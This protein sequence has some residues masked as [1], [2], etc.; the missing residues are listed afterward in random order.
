MGL[1]NTREPVKPIHLNWGMSFLRV[2]PSLISSWMQTFTKICY[3]VNETLWYLNIRGFPGGSDDR[4]STCNARDLSSIPG[5]GRWS[6]EGMATHSSILVWRFPWTEEPSG[7]QSTGSQKVRHSWATRHT[8][9]HLNPFPGFITVWDV[10]FKK[11]SVYWHV[12]VRSIKF[13]L[14]KFFLK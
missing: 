6:E 4:E 13:V 9:A 7:L 12:S 3:M 10:F 8:H 1:K 5:L 14:V 11:V 2:M